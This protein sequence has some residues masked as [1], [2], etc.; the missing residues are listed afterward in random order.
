MPLIEEFLF[1]KAE[2]FLNPTDTEG[3]VKKKIKKR[4]IPVSFSSRVLKS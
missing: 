3:A 1:S 2:T 4:N